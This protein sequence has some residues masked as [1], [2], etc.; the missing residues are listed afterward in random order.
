MTEPTPAAT[1]VPLRDGPGGIE[2]L[3]LRRNSRGAFGGMWVFPGGQV[4]PGDMAL[5]PGG[6]TGHD[7][8]AEISAARRAAVREAWEEAGLD[9]SHRE[10]VTLSFWIPPPA[11]PRRFATWFFLAEADGEVVVDQGEIHD[12]QWM[13]PSAAMAARDAGEVELAPPTYTTLW[14]VGRQDDVKSA[15]S[16][17]ASRTPERFATHLGFESDGS[18]AATLWQGD[19]GYE[20][21]D[22]GRPGPRRR[23][24]MQPAGWRVEIDG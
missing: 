3:L 1:V 5:E 18:L 2:V 4:D 7:E 9:L 21:G 15:L 22:I 16:E 24:W 14:W 12:H 11:A 13:S 19:A 10:L 23:L 6:V 20:D 8:S 17:A